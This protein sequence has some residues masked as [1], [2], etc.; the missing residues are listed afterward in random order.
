MTSIVPTFVAVPEG[1]RLFTLYSTCFIVILGIIGNILNIL[2]F[3]TLKLFRGNPC[4]FYFTFESIMNIG[5]LITALILNTIT[6]TRTTDTISCKIQSMLIEIFIPLSLTTVC[7]AS[8][9][10][11]F[12]TS[13][14]AYFRQWNTLKS[15]RL[16]TCIAVCIWILHSIPIGIFSY[17][18]MRIICILSDLKFIHYQLYFYYP[19]LLGILPMSISSIFSLLAFRNVRKIIRRQIPIDRRRLDQ[20]MTALVFTRVIVLV[21]LY[22]PYVIYHMYWYNPSINQTNYMYFITLYSIGAF[23]NSFILL[24]N[25]IPFY[26]FLAVSSRYR[27]QVKSFLVK[28]IWRRCKRYYHLNRN[29]IIP[30]RK[31][32]DE[33]A[34]NMD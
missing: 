24:N 28:K 22:L 15:S 14:I 2:V 19:I 34:T 25:G 4:S 17:S 5:S 31:L 20:Q 3:N 21:V 1:I 29:Q 18:Y 26:I 8:I 33:L 23:I 12:S 13:P 6:I 16:Y 9:D 32:S 30:S 10:Q 7:L 11:F 27:R